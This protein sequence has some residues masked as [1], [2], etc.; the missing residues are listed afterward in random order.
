M[1]KNIASTF[2]FTVKTT[3]IDSNYLTKDQMVNHYNRNGAFTTK[4]GLSANLKNLKWFNHQNA[5]DFFPRCYKL[6]NDDDRTAFIEDYRI[7]C[8]VSLLKYCLMKYYGQPDEDDLEIHITSLDELKLFTEN[9]IKI[10]DIKEEE[11]DL[12]AITLNKPPIV[13]NNS[14]SLLHSSSPNNN[15][16]TKTVPLEAIHIAIDQLKKFLSFCRHEDIDSVVTD[17]NDTTK[18]VDDINWIKFQEWF[19]TACQ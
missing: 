12:S 2:I 18:E 1:L 8:C 10:E 3:N 16:K 19:Y 13:N 9:N 7:T 14:K 17:N 6:C 4:I 11:S 15:K 5:D